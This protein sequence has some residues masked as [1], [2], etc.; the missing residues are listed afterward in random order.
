MT[1]VYITNVETGQVLMMTCHAN[2]QV[3]CEKDPRWII[4]KYKVEVE[5]VE[6]PKPKP[7]RKPGRPRKSAK[8]E[9]PK[10][11]EQ[12]ASDPEVDGGIDL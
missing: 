9:E 1:P 3:R 6:E 4:G 8:A 2:A 5:P 7:K 10:Q 12:A 11:E